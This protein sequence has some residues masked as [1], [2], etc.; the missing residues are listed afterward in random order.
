MSR[1]VR[2][3]TRGSAL[4]AVL[5]VALMCLTLS[6][7]SRWTTTSSDFSLLKKPRMSPDSVVLELAFVHVSE[8]D[9]IWRDVDEQHLAVEL[10]REL[11][12]QGL[13]GGL[14]GTQLPAW[15]SE[16][17]EEQEKM[18]DFDEK[19]GTAS[20]ADQESP[21]RLQCRSA[22]TREIEI[23]PPRE[24]LVLAVDDCPLETERT[25]EDA[26]CRLSVI[27]HAQGDGRVH[28][29][30]TPEIAHG[31]PRHRWVGSDGSFRIHLSQDFERYD[32]LSISV[33]LSPGQTFVLTGTGDTPGLAQHFFPVGERLPDHR[34]V[35]LLRLAQTQ[36][37]DLFCPQP[38]FT[39]IA[40]D[41]Q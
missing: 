1:L 16:R 31:A 30:I 28:L 36:L 12:R 3:Q 23:G 8:Q 6:G 7:C 32:N 19:T 39:P 14:T 2:T 11:Q 4:P 33:V 18:I 41:M 27:S 40:T 20:M 13:R 24:R 10:R 21:Q 37:D 29:Q 25:L 5:A 34:R 26:Y 15:I 38:I 22:Q 9:D 17:L 35:F